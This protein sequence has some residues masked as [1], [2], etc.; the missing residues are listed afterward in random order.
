MKEYARKPE[1][2]SRT[3][4]S[5]TKASR[6]APISEILQ[7]YKDRIDGKPVQR[8]SVDEEE[9]LQAKSAQQDHIRAVLQRYEPEE[10]EELLQGKFES[11]STT[12]QE[13]VQQEEKP[14]NTGLPNNLKTGIENLSGFS[15]DDVK[16]HYNSDK[17][18][19]LNALAYAQ[20]TDIHVAPGQEKHLP[21]EAWHVVQQK[22]GHVQPTLQ[23][24]GINVNDNEGLEKEADLMGDQTVIAGQKKQTRSK[25]THQTTQMNWHQ[26]ILQMMPTIRDVDKTMISKLVIEYISEKFD[27]SEEKAKQVLA[28]KKLLADTG[29]YESI[30]IFVDSHLKQEEVTSYFKAVESSIE[31]KERGDETESSAASIIGG[32]VNRGK[33]GRDVEWRMIKRTKADKLKTK[34]SKNSDQELFESWSDILF[35][36]NDP[37]LQIILSTP[38]DAFSS[39]HIALAGGPAKFKRDSPLELDQTAKNRI[40]QLKKVAR[41][42]EYTAILVFSADT[43][44]AQC[45]AVVSDCAIDVVHLG[46]KQDDLSN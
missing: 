27:L 12:E 10:D 42:L 43:T 13:P 40:N 29:N 37:D 8:Q 34:Y 3:I 26:D 4:Q 41:L 14:N 5:N 44:C 36:E 30:Q 31:S 1:N 17:P 21:H 24:Q 28:K 39:T 20:G 32:Q 7:A 45:R 18:A 46:D 6:Q 11:T 2:T 33:G 15:M 22:Q 35:K 23:L 38:V 9:L 19:Q 16:V 25:K